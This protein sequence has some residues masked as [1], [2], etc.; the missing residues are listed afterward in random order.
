MLDQAQRLQRQFFRS[1]HVAS[2]PR[3]EPPVDIVSCGREV[4]VTVALPGVAPEHVHVRIDELGLHIEAV[5][6]LPIDE[7]TS[8]VHRLEIPYGRYERRIALPQGRYELVEQA[9]THGCL[10]LRLL[11]H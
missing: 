10:Q 11:Q 3:W 1:A 4:R 5:R 2:Q 8:A 9:C 6:R 7:H